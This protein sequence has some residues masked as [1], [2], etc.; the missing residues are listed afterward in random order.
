M[1]EEVS[2]L[3]F[4]Q[5]RFNQRFLSMNNEYSLFIITETR[6]QKRHHIESKAF[7]YKYC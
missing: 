3:F 1:N 6:R 7:G 4:N 2:L 5:P